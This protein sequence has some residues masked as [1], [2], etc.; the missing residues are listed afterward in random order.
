MSIILKVCEPRAVVLPPASSE[1]E[2]ERNGLVLIPGENS[3]SE[4]YF[5]AIGNNPG[6]VIMFQSGCLQNLGVGK[7][8]SLADG[9]DSY[10][11]PEARKVIA[12]ISKPE[13]LKKLKTG[14]KTK[15]IQD[16]INERVSALEAPEAE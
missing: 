6:V 9:L 13:V 1:V 11:V 7:A 2:A 10:S 12:K 15:G 5:S 4:L 14:T 8:K 3:V 16:A